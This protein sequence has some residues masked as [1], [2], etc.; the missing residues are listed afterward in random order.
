[1]ARIY[2][3]NTVDVAALAGRLIACAVAL[4]GTSGFSVLD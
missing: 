4:G 1:V 3:A 2:A